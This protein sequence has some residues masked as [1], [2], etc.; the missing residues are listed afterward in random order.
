MEYID[1]EGR[2]YVVVGNIAFNELG[3][4]TK[5]VETDDGD[6]VVIKRFGRWVW[7]RSEDDSL[8]VDSYVPD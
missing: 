3:F 5:I 7:N 8:R 6:K 2:K 1:V 4:P